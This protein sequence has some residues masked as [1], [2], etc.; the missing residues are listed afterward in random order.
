LHLLAIATEVPTN[1]RVDPAE[2]FDRIRGGTGQLIGGFQAD[3]QLVAYGV[4][5]LTLP[6][7]FELAELLDEDAAL[8]C[9]LDG[10]GVHPD[11]RGQRLHLSSID[12]RLRRGAGF[13]RRQAAATVAPQ[14]IH[15]MSG[16]MRAGFEIKRF[17]ILYGGQHR[18][19]MQRDLRQASNPISG[20]PRRTTLSLPVTDVPGHQAA[21]AEGLV[22]HGCHQDPP[23]DW[24]VD[25]G[26]P[27]MSC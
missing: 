17:A 4:L 12:E 25:Y 24:F 19:V 23:G 21:L 1:V 9:V 16:L 2:H 26:P 8:L 22:G 18:F 3:G 27:S 10:C 14:N 13:G 5:A 7:V 11:C 20:R 15:S 6:V